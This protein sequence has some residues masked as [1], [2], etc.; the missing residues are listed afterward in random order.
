M[1]S[2]EDTPMSCRSRST[3]WTFR[4]AIHNAAARHAGL[5]DLC[6]KAWYMM[7][8]IDSWVKVDI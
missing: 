3:T 1:T 7:F 6:E 2:L 8:I 4:G 5:A